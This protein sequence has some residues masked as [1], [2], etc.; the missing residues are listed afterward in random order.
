MLRRK[1]TVERQRF[2]RDTVILMFCSLFNEE[3][4]EPFCLYVGGGANRISVPGVLDTQKTHI[5]CKACFSQSVY[6]FLNAP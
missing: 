4:E 1:G 5:S 2:S 3:K 6:K